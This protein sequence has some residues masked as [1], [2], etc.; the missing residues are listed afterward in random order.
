MFNLEAT[1]PKLTRN[2]CLHD[3]KVAVLIIVHNGKGED[4][5][6]P[7]TMGETAPKEEGMAEAPTLS[8]IVLLL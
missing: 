6:I 1:F 5:P 4:T 2:F 7:S 3:F 8:K